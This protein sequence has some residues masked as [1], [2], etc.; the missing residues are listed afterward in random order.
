MTRRLA[1]VLP[2][3]LAGCPATLECP[4]GEVD[5]GG[6]CVSLADDALNCGACGFAC[7]SGACEGGACACPP[8]KTE[9]GGGC[10]DLA[11]DPDHCATCQVACAPVQVC[12]ASACA[13]ACAAGLVDCDRACVDL[14]TDR[15]HCGACDVACGPGQSCDGGTCRALFV[16]CFATDDVRTVSPDL[17]WAGPVRAAGDGPISLAASA[18]R[19]YAASSISHSL[20]ALPLDPGPGTEFLFPG[21]SDLENVV[22]HGGRLYVSNSGG[23]TL[24]VVDPATGAVMDEVGFGVTTVNPRGVAFVGDVAYVALYGLDESTGGQE[25]AVVDFAGAGTCSTPPCGEVI[26]RISV[27]AGADAPGLPFPSRAL[28][29]GGTVYVTLANLRKGDLGYY[30]EPAGDGRLAVIDASNE[31]AL[32]YLSLPGC[33]NPGGLALRGTT[34]WVACGALDTQAIL[35]VDVSGDA[36]VPGN[37]VPTPSPTPGASDFVPGTI[38]FCGDM[39]YVTDQWSGDLIRFDPASPASQSGL[40]VCP[41]SAPPE[42]YGWAWAADVA[43]AP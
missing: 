7:S 28:A 3:L 14:G 29:V 37:P 4:Q 8:G 16:A 15:Y 5:C 39:G 43:C 32:S 9:C 35:P 13:G 24:L 12:S 33:R 11:T 40:S 21:A 20:T 1:L 25:I 22:A 34:I 26:G 2:A 42:E 6:R 27:L 18:D 19:V 23:G 41:L 31:D 17:A 38:A 30:T 36:P 10:V